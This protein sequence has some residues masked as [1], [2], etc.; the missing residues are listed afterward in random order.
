MSQDLAHATQVDEAT[1]SIESSIGVDRELSSRTPLP[2]GLGEAL[3]TARTRIAPLWPLESFVAVN[4]FLSLTGE[5]FAEAC[6]V[7]KQ[8]AGADML[9]PRAYYRELLESG[10]ISDEDLRS[11]I[12]AVERSTSPIDDAELAA[13]KSRVKTGPFYTSVTSSTVADVLDR[14]RGTRAAAEVTE[15]V[16]KW[17]SAYW[18]EGQAAWRMPWQTMP[19]YRA[20]RA[21]SE[22]DRT[23]DV[24]GFAG[25]REAIATLPDEPE[26]AI[27]TIVSA[28]GLPEAAL[29]AY[30][31]RALFSVRGWAAYARYLG[32]S[33]ELDGA[34]NERVIELLAV[35]LAW[36][37]A[38]F[39]LHRDEGFRAA[40]AEAVFEM[41]E[42]AL[43]TDDDP[44]LFVDTVLQA[45]FDASF[46]RGLLEKLSTKEP[47][48]NTV[49]LTKPLQA[50]FCI[51]VRSEV[52][53]RALESVAPEAQTIGFAGFFGFPIEYVPIGQ[54]AGAAQCPVLL[55]PKFVVQETVAGADEDEHAEI[56][57][58]RLLRRRA[59]KAW[60]SFK[61]SAVSSFVYVETAGL[62][63]ASKLASDAL[64]VTRTVKHPSAEGLDDKV[65]PRTGPEIAQ[66]E[67]GGRITGF[68]R[69]Q[70]VDMAEGVLKA[71]SLRSGFARLVMLAGHGSTTVNNP[72]ASGL[73]CGA[74]GGNSGEANARV[75]AAILN[76]PEVRA[77]L[78]ERG[79]QITEETWFLG[80]LH[81]TTTDEITIFDR[82]QIPESHSEA[83]QQLE[84]WLAEASSIARSER[85]SRLG[86]PTSADVDK[87]IM[88]RSRDWSQP[89]P[90]WGLAGNAAFIAAPRARTRGVDLDGRVFLHDYDWK[91]DEEFSVLE[92]IMTA[93]MVVAS[94][95]NMQYYGSAVNTQAFGCGNKVLHNVV[96]TIGVLQGNGGDLQTGL[97]WQSVHDGSRY[98]HEPLR[99]NVFIEAPTEQLEAVLEKHDGVADLVE[100]QWVHLFA[101][102]DDGK[103]CLRYVGDGQ[104]APAYVD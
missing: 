27:A 38:L 15:Q 67:V 45:A 23:P 104:W 88:R 64:G 2:V 1:A 22:V 32:W 12:A 63:F 39:S 102:V 72:H 57:G 29:D 82:E 4:P 18:D 9:M 91:Q 100:N 5:R 34:K 79:I 69:E 40:W 51:D 42:R 68:S 84:A 21:A 70:R 54:H 46:Q 73:D 31:F 80:C 81:D 35:R 33:H 93:P 25:F 36:D 55:N 98:V 101:L 37:Y 59:A 47:E 94:W 3:D 99:L 50:A 87:N 41:E 43:S 30:F 60:K 75:A 44:D 97:S 76:D 83:L 13:W 26:E 62:T 20:W 66:A 90:E 61:S 95:I 14:T 86:V 24:L 89:R 6:R 58:L 53:R 52:F 17:S 77:G 48:P 49:P 56:L 19:F 85:A 8:V 103:A 96:G 28:L 16:S 78:A 71:M 7:M 10:R 74:C 11:A 92:L 65:L